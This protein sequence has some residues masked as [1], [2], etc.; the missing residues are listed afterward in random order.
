MVPTLLFR[1]VAGWELTN[2]GIVTI[3]KEVVIIAPTLSAS[4]R[5]GVCQ[6]M[7]ATKLMNR[8]VTMTTCR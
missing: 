8:F 5:I 4:P 7:S 6:L 3:R 2:P 1:H